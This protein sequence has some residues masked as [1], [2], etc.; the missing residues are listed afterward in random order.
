M[1]IHLKIGQ[2]YLIQTHR[3]KYIYYLLENAEM[4][5]IDQTKTKWGKI[6]IEHM[7]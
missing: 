1:Q 3:K 6:E 7:K 5:H 4:M 2:N